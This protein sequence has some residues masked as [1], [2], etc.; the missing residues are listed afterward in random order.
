M[1][2]KSGK[3]VEI[4]KH[5]VV[6]AARAT[7]RCRRGCG[8][9]ICGIRRESRERP[10]RRSADTP[11]VESAVKAEPEVV[12]RRP[13][14]ELAVRRPGAGNAPRCTYSRACCRRDSRRPQAARRRCGRQSVRGTGPRRHAHCARGSPQDEAG[15]RA[16][17]MTTA[18]LPRST[19][20]APKAG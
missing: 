16:H 20:R 7:V 11:A 2:D 14:L 6:H 4:V 19:C 10:A 12:V 3:I 9:R 17:P 13:E 1:V 8:C 5:K 15:G 18:S